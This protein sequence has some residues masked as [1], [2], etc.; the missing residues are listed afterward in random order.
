MFV[1]GTWE[2]P[3][4][5]SGGACHALIDSCAPAAL[6]WWQDL[7]QAATK[8]TGSCSCCGGFSHILGVRKYLMGRK[9]QTGAA[10]LPPSKHGSGLAKRC[11][12][13]PCHV[14]QAL[15]QKR[16]MSGTSEEIHVPRTL[17]RSY[18]RTWVTYPAFCSGHVPC[19]KVT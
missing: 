11:S 19:S 6:R 14:H 13:M 16:V 1:P 9:E 15:P 5:W 2:L 4:R 10:P 7:I 18:F 17:T 8:G 3:V 12:Q